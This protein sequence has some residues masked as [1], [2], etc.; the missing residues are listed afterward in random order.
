MSG[1]PPQFPMHKRRHT[2]GLDQLGPTP[3][4]VL[5]SALE[6]EHRSHLLGSHLGVRHRA[7]LSTAGRKPKITLPRV[8]CLERP[9]EAD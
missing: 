2:Q 7:A 6:E 4:Y 3:S 8:S 1:A 9:P 5:R